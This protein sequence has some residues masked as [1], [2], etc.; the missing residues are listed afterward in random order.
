M[1]SIYVDSEAV[2][3]VNDDVDDS[4]FS[5]SF[6]LEMDSASIEKRESELREIVEERNHLIHQMLIQFDQQFME[7][8]Q[9]LG[10]QLDAQFTKLQTEHEKLRLTA[11]MLIE[12]SEKVFS[13]MKKSL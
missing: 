3:D 13:D 4:H 9:E 11:K 5:F 7:S 10:E 6:K 1:S 2:R 8:C 12:G